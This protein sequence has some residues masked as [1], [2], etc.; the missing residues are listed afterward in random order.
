MNIKA[1]LTNGFARNV[2][3]ADRIVRALLALSV[4]AL[5]LSGMIGGLAA[6]ALSVLAILILRTSFTGKCGIYYGLGLSTYHDASQP[7]PSMSGERRG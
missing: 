3:P 7:Q 4:P 2:G 5:Y 6:I 1:M